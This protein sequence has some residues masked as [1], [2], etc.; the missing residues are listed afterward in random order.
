MAF[1]SFETPDRLERDGLPSPSHKANTGQIDTGWATT[2]AHPSASPLYLSPRQDSLA[3][4][5]RR[6]GPPSPCIVG[7]GEDVDVGMG[8]LNPVWGTGIA[9]R[10]CLHLSSSFEMYWS[11]GLH[12]MLLQIWCLMAQR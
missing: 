1:F 5:I 4:T 6:S 2:R 12:T 10:P 8:P 7:A 3:P 9:A 11:Q